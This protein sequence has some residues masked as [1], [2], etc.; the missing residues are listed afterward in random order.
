MKWLDYAAVEFFENEDR[1]MFW[2]VEFFLQIERKEFHKS[3]VVFTLG[4][5]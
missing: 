3:D 4:E 2:R 1:G 5:N